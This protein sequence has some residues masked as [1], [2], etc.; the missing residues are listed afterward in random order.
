M[1]PNT[2]PML[3]S[4]LRYPAQNYNDEL[5]RACT[6]L[7]DPHGDLK[8]F[9]DEIAGSSPEHLQELFTRTFD[10]SKTCALEVGW[11]LYG[12]DYERGRFIATMRGLLREYGIEES[13]ELPDH[14]SHVLLLLSRLPAAEQA[15]LVSDAVLPALEKMDQG[16]KEKGT[17]YIHLVSAIRAH[18]Q[19]LADSIKERSTDG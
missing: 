14:L 8:R 19:I 10:M 5:Q 16:V 3:S 1:N 13:V 11:H 17:P 4:L 12:E 6:M 15:W 2:L 9:A 18:L 7:G